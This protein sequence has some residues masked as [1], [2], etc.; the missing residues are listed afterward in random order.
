[1]VAAAQVGVHRGCGDVSNQVAGC[2]RTV[3]PA[4]ETRVCVAHTIGQQRL[5]LLL[6]GNWAPALDG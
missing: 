1:M 5:D 2:A 6:N 4:E 3:H